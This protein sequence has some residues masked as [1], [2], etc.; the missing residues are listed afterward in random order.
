MLR[1]YIK[2]LDIYIYIYIYIYMV[3]VRIYKVF[4]YTSIYIC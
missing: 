3:S 4:L 2:V 1:M